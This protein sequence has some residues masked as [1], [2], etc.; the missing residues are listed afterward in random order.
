M[1][2]RYGGIQGIYWMLSGAIFGFTTVFLQTRGYTNYSIGIVFTLGNIL[3]FTVQPIIA[4]F[5][6]RRAKAPL[7]R[8]ISLTAMLSFLLMLLVMFLPKQ[9]LPL[10]AIFI[11]VIAMNAL[12]SPLCIS[13]C[14]YVCTWGYKLDFSRARAIGSLTYA[15][16]TAGLGILIERVSANSMPICYFVLSALLG[17]LAVSIGSYDPNRVDGKIVVRHEDS[18]GILEFLKHNK[19]FTMFLLGTSMLYF[20]HSLITNFF[21]EFIRSAGGDSTDLGFLVAFAAIIEVPV[22]LFFDRLTKHFRCST[23]LLFSVSMMTVKALAIFLARSIP[24]F[25]FAQ[26]IQMFAF[27]ILVPATVR[28]VDLIIEKRDAVKGQSYASCV[29]TLG[30]IFASYCGGLLLDRFGVWETLLCGLLVSAVGTL[31]TLFSIQK[32]E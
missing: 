14:F 3:G 13:L 8:V 4:G 15:I 25:Y 16:T 19:R 32:T 23:L 27:A 9:S 5:V 28:Y 24:M 12:L 29:I 6:D 30:S 10:S 7:V 17:M 11:I 20:T 21:I 2:I 26:S 18:S 31:I 22:M 1:N